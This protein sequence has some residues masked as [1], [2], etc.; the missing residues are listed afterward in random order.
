MPGRFPR[1]PRLPPWMKDPL[2]SP[3]TTAAALTLGLKVGQEAYKLKSGEIS[4]EEF[5]RRAGGHIGSVSGTLMGAAVGAV[6]GIWAPG[7]GTVMGAFSGGFVGQVM[8]EHFGRKGAERLQRFVHPD[9]ETRKDMKKRK[10]AE[11]A[12]EP[13]PPRG[14]EDPKDPPKRSL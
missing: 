10:R 9:A 11:A 13:E 7:L 6:A 1:L 14:P 8:G 4:A 3:V 2:K 5:E 12:A